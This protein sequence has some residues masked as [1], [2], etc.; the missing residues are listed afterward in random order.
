MNIDTKREIDDDNRFDLL[1]R[2]CCRNTKL[3]DFTY[4]TENERICPPEMCDY[5]GRDGGK[6]EFTQ[7]RSRCLNCGHTFIGD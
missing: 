5:E 6:C 4:C 1:H 7:H 3:E 2:T